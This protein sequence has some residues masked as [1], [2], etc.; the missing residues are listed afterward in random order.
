V[1]IDL[2]RDPDYQER[3]QAIRLLG[4]RRDQEVAEALRVLAG[5]PDA[6]V[7]EVARYERQRQESARRRALRRGALAGGPLRALTTFVSQRLGLTSLR[8]LAVEERL[9]GTPDAQVWVKVQAR[10]STDAELTHR[11]KILLLIINWGFT[12]VM[13]LLGFLFVACMWLA[14]IMAGVLLDHVA[15]SVA[16][17]VLG[18]ITFIPRVHEL[19]WTRARPAIAVARFGFYLLVTT[20]I[21]AAV[22]FVW[23]IPLCAVAVV[24]AV[25]V[26]REKRRQRRCTKQIRSACR[27]R[28]LGIVASGS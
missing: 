8:E 24:T 17:F 2:A 11:Y 9:N 22:A 3:I 12:L 28:S 6:K 25:L 26:G 21:C 10:V 15:I 5:D 19:R 16:L 13:C 14:L 23:W 4:G 7:R 20:I 27:S 18:G 1:L